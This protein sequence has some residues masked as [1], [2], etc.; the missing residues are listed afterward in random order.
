M[1]GSAAGSGGEEQSVMVA[2]ANVRASGGR[3]VVTREARQEFLE[4]G[5]GEELITLYG[6][7]SV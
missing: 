4:K 1:E 6:G 2:E 7:L 3:S 5:M